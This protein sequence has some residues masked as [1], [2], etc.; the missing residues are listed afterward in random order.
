MNTEKLKS[1]FETEA[2]GF[3][4]SIEYGVALSRY[5]YYQIGGP[6]SVLITPKSIEDLQIVHQAILRL[7][8]PYF[9]LGW[10]SNLLFS[11]S[12]YGGLVIRMKYLFSEVKE[13]AEGEL[14][15]GASVGGS[16]LLRKAQEKGWGGLSHLTGIPGSVGGMIAMNAGTHLGEMKDC[17]LQVDSIQ[18]SQSSF[19]I[20]SRVT[21]PQD[22]SYRRNHFLS[23]GELVTQVR[24]KY[25]PSDPA[26]IKKEIDHLYQRRKETQPVDYPS[27]GSVF[28][29]PKE[30]GLHAWQVVDR[31]GLRGHR[32]GNAQIS[33]KHS[34]FIVNLGGAKAVEVKS[35]ID[36]VKARAKS[37][38]GIEMHEEVKIIE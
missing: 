10:G 16:T 13:I 24:L 5:S 34:N 20:R 3:N 36:L 8:I 23:E 38:L 37:E 9:I 11:D 19:E 35:L 31:L 17:A 26:I 30:A 14:Q 21:Q 29:N 15:A 2:S 12:G 22:F 28:I 27:C 6:A 33:E 4:G 7:S 25:L 1:Y 18:L 32:I